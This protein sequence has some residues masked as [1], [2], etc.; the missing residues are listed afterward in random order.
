[1]EIYDVE[2]L[3]MAIAVNMFSLRGKLC[4]EFYS[5]ATPNVISENL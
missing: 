4:Y 1:M 3:R 5:D 2:K